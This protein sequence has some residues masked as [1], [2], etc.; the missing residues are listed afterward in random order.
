LFF[1]PYSDGNGSQ[2]ILDI[3]YEEYEDGMWKTVSVAFI[4][5]VW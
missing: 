2:T 4:N 3:Y 1:S 5:I